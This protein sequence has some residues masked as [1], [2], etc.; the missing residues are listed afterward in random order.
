MLKYTEFD[1]QK[2]RDLLD[3]H[4]SAVAADIRLIGHSGDALARNNMEIERL[5][6]IMSD[7][8]REVFDRLL[9]QETAADLQK[10]RETLIITRHEQRKVESEIAENNEREIREAD[11]SVSIARYVIGGGLVILILILLFR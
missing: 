11:N 4:A 5:R 3:E 9:E 8:E 1:R 7:T 2:V 6:E 10:A